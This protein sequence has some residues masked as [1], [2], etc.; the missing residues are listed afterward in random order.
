MFSKISQTPL[1]RGLEKS[2]IIEVLS[3]VHY[4]TRIYENN[5]IIA[6]AGNKCEKLYILLKG[7]VRAEMRNFS[8]VDVVVRDIIAPDTFAE[9]YLFA[10]DNSF[11]TNIIANIDTEILIIQKADFLKLLNNNMQVMSNYLNIISNRFTLVLQKLKFLSIRTVEGKLANYI[12]SLARA[13]KGEK[14][15]KLGK[16]HEDLA[17][18]FGITR[19]ALTRNLLKLKKNA[20][21][22]IHGKEIEIIDKEKLKMMCSFSK[23][24][25][26]F[27]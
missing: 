8:G 3:E 15:F 19:P 11:K 12:L 21:I 6:Y 2:K 22:E 9:A 5:S 7:S 24:K 16:T 18:L 10:N 1:F 23:G 25:P 14:S 4:Q 13:N 20:L 17:A 27:G 26:G